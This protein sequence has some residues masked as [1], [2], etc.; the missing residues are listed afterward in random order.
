MVNQRRL[1]VLA[2]CLVFS[3][4]SIF[5]AP[6]KSDQY[7][8]II[9][10]EAKKH[11]MPEALIYAVIR[12]E[13]RFNHLAVSP[14]GA[15]GLMQL[16][17]ATA[18]RFN[19][20]DAFIPAE[21]IRAG[22]TY[23]AWLLKRFKGNVRFALAGYNAGEG[24]VDRYNGIPPY[25]ETRHYVTKVMGYYRQYSG[26]SESKKTTEQKTK[27]AAVSRP[28]PKA[29]KQVISKAKR[30]TNLASAKTTRKQS[31]QAFRRIKPGAVTRFESF[32]R[33][34]SI[35]LAMAKTQ[36]GYTRYRARVVR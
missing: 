19:V 13:S 26:L 35:T 31:R 8:R 3:G 18:K 30:S 10:A 11:K 17:P 5:A 28:T 7:D 27:V 1:I 32:K 25:K 9:F 2:L 34:R 15:M 24:K 20:K 29:R 22:V 33:V 12:Q 4:N 36:T 6:P 14:A 21:N 23:L 16:M